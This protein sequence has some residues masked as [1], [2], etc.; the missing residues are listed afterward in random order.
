MAFERDPHKLYPH[1]YIFK[2]TILPLIPSFVTPNSITVLRFVL[3]PFVLW[4]LYIG[5]Y[6]LGVPLFLFTALTDALDGSLARTRKQITDW[7]TFYDPVADKLLI[8]PVVLIIVAT[9]VN[10]VFA[11]VI[12]LIELFIIAGGYTRRKKGHITSANIF[13]KTKMFLQVIGVGFLLISV[14]LGYDLFID[15]SIGTL[16]LAIVF[17]VISLFTYGL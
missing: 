7:G 3:T 13:G 17:A 5:N 8:S 12:V 6:E 10:V 1:D 11:F 4:L 14:W 2:Y 9:H 15:V 16:S